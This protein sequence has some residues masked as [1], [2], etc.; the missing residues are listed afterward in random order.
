MLMQQGVGRS[1]GCVEDFFALICTWHEE[2]IIDLKVIQ[3]EHMVE[4]GT[5]S[6]IS[7]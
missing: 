2:S 6:I 5:I 3:Y 1:D 4:I 7:F